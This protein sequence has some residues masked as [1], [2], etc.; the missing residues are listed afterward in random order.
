M[1]YSCVPGLHLHRLNTIKPESFQMGFATHEM[2]ANTNLDF[3]QC[4]VTY[5]TDN[6]T[7]LSPVDLHGTSCSYY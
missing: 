1:H 7:L 2:T 5:S 6:P 4:N 3:T